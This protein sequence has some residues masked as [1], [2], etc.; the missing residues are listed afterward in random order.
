MSNESTCNAILDSVTRI[1][2]C[3]TRFHSDVADAVMKWHACSFDSCRIRIFQLLKEWVATDGECG[4]RVLVNLHSLGRRKLFTEDEFREL[5]YVFLQCDPS[6][7]Y[8][9]M[10][11]FD[12]VI[13][14]YFPS[15]SK[16]ASNGFILRNLLFNRIETRDHSVAYSEVPEKSASPKQPVVERS[17]LCPLI[18]FFC[19][20]TATVAMTVVVNMRLQSEVQPNAS[21][22]PPAMKKRP[23][24]DSFEMMEK[25]MPVVEVDL[26]IPEEDGL[27][28]NTQ[29]GGFATSSQ[30]EVF[31]T[32]A[33]MRDSLIH[34]MNDESVAQPPESESS[35]SDEGVII[36]EEE[37]VF[38]IED[39]PAKSEKPATR[40][41]S[42]EKE[43]ITIPTDSSGP[44]FF[45]TVFT[46]L[47]LSC[48]LSHTNSRIACFLLCW[49]CRQP[50]PPIETRDMYV[51]PIKE[52]PMEMPPRSIGLKTI[53]RCPD[54]L[55]LTRERSNARR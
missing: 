12:S 11:T 3:V 9:Y 39:A 38:I 18:S 5:F 46:L 53:P 40:E 13:E 15:S 52:R 1:P 25:Q 24:F 30:S 42:H 14:Y 19:L 49:R 50:Q 35:R 10:S 32:H 2:K 33:E 27:S 22:S 4:V 6:F 29:S 55:E 8:Q 23:N 44:S 37:T 47:L 21:Q 36:K 43:T 34:S 45:A 26:S 51:T 16:S 31:P 41:Y 17:S 54:S 7:L 20:V 48:T 28:I